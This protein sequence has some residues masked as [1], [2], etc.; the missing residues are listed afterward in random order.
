MFA[1]PTFT[2]WLEFL[3]YIAG[4]VIGN[5]ELVV[6]DTHGTVGYAA[7]QCQSSMCRHIPLFGLWRI[8]HDNR[9]L[10]W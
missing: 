1:K 8:V 10:R 7:S 3:D 6:I 4:L 2:E 5:F 9:G